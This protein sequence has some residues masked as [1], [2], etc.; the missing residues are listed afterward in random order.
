MRG[1]VKAFI[2]ALLTIASWTVAASAQIAGSGQ[3]A[4]E[5]EPFSG[6]DLI[7]GKRI[8][9]QQCAGLAGAVWVVVNGRGDC[10]RYY[11]SGAGGG[12]NEAIVFFSADLVLTNGRGESKPVDYY[13]K[14]TAAEIG[15][16]SVSWS[17]ALRMPYVLLARPGTYGSS[18]EHSKRRTPQEIEL[19][20]AALDAIKA[21]HGFT[22]LHLAG[23][24]YGAHA[25]ASLLARRT[26]VGCAVLASGFV[27]VKM[28]LAEFKT[29]D[30]TGNKNP[31]D[32]IGLV[33]QIAKRP[34]LKIYVLTDPDDVAIS[35]RSQT[36]YVRRLSAAGLQVRQIFA[37]ASDVSRHQLSRE[38]R[39]VAAA[40]AKGVAADTI[41]AIPE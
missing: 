20:S 25:P 3:P 32:P 22:R 35:A 10:I 21:R 28:R 39:L 11:Y 23:A 12:W 38:A 30:I 2:G 31:V 6:P 36:A 19:L 40:C 26:D 24:S 18:G 5:T 16:G 15:N 34:D 37:S 14:E 13:L 7:S 8:S 27:A 33:D 29:A 17:R 1:G 41:V 9:E 4:F